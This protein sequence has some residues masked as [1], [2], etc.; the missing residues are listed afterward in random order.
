MRGLRS[1]FA[2]TLRSYVACEVDEAVYA[3]PVDSVQEIIQPLPLTALPH[4]PPGVIGA[5]EH[6]NQV[7]P[8]LDLGQRLGFGPTL[9]AR[10]KWVLMR[11]GARVLGLVVNHVFEVFQSDPK[12]LRP[13]PALAGDELRGA[14]GVLDFRGK[15]AF[16]LDM[17]VVSQLAE[18]AEPGMSSQ[19]QDGATL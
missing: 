15:M 8:I 4:S 11:E 13:V 1:P 3:V 18:L 17:S 16:L 9:S 7:V 14:T 2:A 19:G 5:I 10:R 6:R 12:E